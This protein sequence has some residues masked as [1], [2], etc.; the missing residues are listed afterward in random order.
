MNPWAS[1]LERASRTLGSRFPLEGGRWGGRT[2]PQHTGLL[3]ITSERPD[4]GVWASRGICLPHPRVPVALRPPPC[5]HQS[6][7]APSESSPQGLGHNLR[8]P[9]PAAHRTRLTPISQPRLPSPGQLSQGRS[10][11]NGYRKEAADA[12]DPSGRAPADQNEGVQRRARRGVP[13]PALLVGRCYVT[14]GSLTLSYR[15]RRPRRAV[16]DSR[17]VRQTSAGVSPL[18]ALYLRPSWP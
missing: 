12:L 10:S 17:G 11:A 15:S 18:H 1:S 2:P 7:R 9:L 8:V 3:G 5:R 13:A 6:P 4:E 14:A 16:R